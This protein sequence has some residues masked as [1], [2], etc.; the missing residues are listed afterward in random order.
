[1]VLPEEL[2]DVPERRWVWRLLAAILILGTAALRIAYLAHDCPLD[3]APDEAHYWDWSR[4]LD[5]SY[6]SKGPLVALLIRASCELFGT[7]ML[8]VRLPAVV[9]GALT[10][11]SI[12]VLTLQVHRRERWALAAVAVA[13]SLPLIAAGSSLM[14]IDA[15]FICAWG[16]ALVF[17]HRA[18][19]RASA[20]AWPGTGICV[21][22]GVLAKHTMVLWVPFFGLFLLT[23]PAFRQLLWSGR[24]WLMTA[25]G[26][27]GGV[28]ILVWNCR[29]G[30]V[31]VLHTVDAHAG[32]SSEDKFDWKGP[33][34]YL[35]GQFLV[36]LGFWFIVWARAAWAHNPVREGRAEIRYLWWMSVPMIAFFLLFSIRNGGGEPNWPVAGYISG[37]VLAVGWLARELKNP[38]PIYRGLTIA[39]TVGTCIVGLTLTIAIHHMSVLA[40]VLEFVAGPPTPQHP[41]PLRRFDPTCRLRGW[42]ELG[43]E[44]DRLRAQLRFEGH[45]PVLAGTSWSLPGEIGFYC[46]GHPAV[47]SLGLAKVF[48]DRHS[49]YDLWH[50]N[51]IDDRDEFLGKT[52]LVIGGGADKLKDAFDSIDPIQMVTYTENGQ[53]IAV[54]G[55]TIARG[56]R[57]GIEIP[58]ANAH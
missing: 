12:Y 54:W 52:F 56:Y 19:F 57:G 15:P 1:M 29:N 23:N 46:E 30:W 27:L 17:G 20:W 45:E 55:V 9:C 39:G 22:V 34:S 21:L 35:G 44:V 28:P 5:W 38:R 31:T 51:P 41:V 32:L 25:L 2:A 48:G 37:M 43:A 36:L 49:Q 13:L 26:A 18:V 11:A 33:L 7:S 4:H 42:H 53:L 16:W 14:T 6:Y 10:L 24:F 58:A 8:A 3:L 40:P 50:P 47:Y